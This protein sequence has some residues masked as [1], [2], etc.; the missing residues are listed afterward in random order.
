VRVHSY[1]RPRI[2]ADSEAESLVHDLSIPIEGTLIQDLEKLQNNDVLQDDMP[3]YI[4]AKLDEPSTD[5]LAIYYV[6]ETAKVRDKV[7]VSYPLFLRNRI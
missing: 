4:L 6:P 2:L 3:A 1:H 7:R 5:W